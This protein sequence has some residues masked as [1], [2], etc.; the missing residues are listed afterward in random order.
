VGWEDLLLRNDGAGKYSNAGDA[1]VYFGQKLMGRGGVVADYDNDGDLDIL[2]T[3]LMDRPVLL[4]NDSREENAWITITLAG[5]GS[6]R[7][8][9]GAR[10]VL[11]LGERTLRRDMRCPT[12]Y[13]CC[14]DPRLHFGLARG[15]RVDRIVVDWPS[16][17][18]QVLRKVAVNRQLTIRHPDGER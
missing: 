12:S 4:R 18:R 7:A 5:R 1:S 2:I 11:H 15:E 3:N 10:V 6:N 16:G 13:L 14:G 17:H 9:L 8:G